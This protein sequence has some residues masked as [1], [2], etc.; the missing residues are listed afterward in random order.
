MRYTRLHRGFTLIELLV[1]ILIIAVLS[2]LL[3]GAVQSARESSRSLACCNN[4]KQL[5][6]ALNGF[7][8][9]Q[10]CLPRRSAANYSVLS[11][12]L[13]Q[14]DNISLFN[15]TNFRI[16][17][18]ESFSEVSPNYTVATTSLSSFACPSDFGVSQTGIASSNYLCNRGMGFDEQGSLENGPFSSAPDGYQAITDGTSNTA[19][20]SESLQGLAGPSS[21]A[22]LRLIF[23]TPGRNVKNSEPGIFSAACTTARPDNAP[24]SGTK[25]QYSW[26]LAD[27][28]NTDYNHIMNVNHNTC[29]N[30][31]LVQQGA[32]TAS[33]FHSGGAHV[34]FVDG[35]V[36][37]R[38]STGALADWRAIGTRNGGEPV[39]D[40]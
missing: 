3:I 7:A 31:D 2:A 39:G 35:S 34:L 40:Y 10:G 24:I 23:S 11:R 20:M 9:Q 38:L 6:I 17:A 5:G 15:S 14:I 32:W 22:S 12:I 37:F 25:K 36:R 1:V 28:M 4:L 16:N 13:S 26:L 21:R 33:S 19:M 30:G 8:S 18:L 29:T 27:Y